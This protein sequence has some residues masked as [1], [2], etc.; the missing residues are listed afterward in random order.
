MNQGIN[1][2]LAVIGGV[3]LAM[4]GGLNAQLGMHLKSPVLATLVAF[5]FS[6]LFALVIVA[7]SLKGGVDI[8][9]FKSVPIYLWFS[10]AFFSVLGISL[11]YHTIP[12]LGISTMIS[13]GLFGQLVFSTVAGHFGW[14]GLP[15][16]PFEFKRILGVTAMTIGILLINKK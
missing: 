4:Q 6:S 16:E 7:S 3:F 13:L 8:S 14:F 10:G 15:K 9:L 1:I 12:R 11:Y 2:F 5:V